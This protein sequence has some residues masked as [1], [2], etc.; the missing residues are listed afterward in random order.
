MDMPKPDWRWALMAGAFL[1]ACGGESPPNPARQK[2]DADKRHCESIS[3]SE[4]AQKSCMQYRGWRDGRFNNAL[5]A[6]SDSMVQTPEAP[7]PDQKR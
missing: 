4:P 6:T 1:A 5:G 2:Y 7:P 3:T